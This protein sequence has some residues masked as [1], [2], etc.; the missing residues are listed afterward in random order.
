MGLINY[1]HRGA[2]E[3]A[4]ENTMTAFHLGVIMGADGIE[5]DVRRTRDG[6]LVLF[7]DANLLR[8]CGRPESISDLTWQ[9]L[10]SLDFGIYKGPAWKGEKIV[11]LEDFL[12]QYG[13]VGL[14]L[15]IEIKDDGVEEETLQMIHRYA[16]PAR[17]VISSFL[18][19][20]LLTVGKLDPEISRGF[21]TRYL[22]EQLL[23]MLDQT[24]IRQICPKASE[25]T[26]AWNQRLREMHFSVRPWGIDNVEIMNCMI[27]LNVDGMT[28]NFPDLLTDRIR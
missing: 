22:N 6:M 17:V 27:D 24:G 16:D 13:N 28:V 18:W 19:R 8:I 1:A 7:H 23:E 21:L 26:P 4:P 5:T 9:E 12:K 25:L 3:Y 14:N 10:L 2:S 15:A 20:S 11:S